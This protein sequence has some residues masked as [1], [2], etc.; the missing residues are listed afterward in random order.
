[1]VVVVIVTLEITVLGARKMT[2]IG[3]IS[4]TY[5]GTGFAAA[6]VWT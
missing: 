5:G 2:F 3:L 1:V 6:A 4:T